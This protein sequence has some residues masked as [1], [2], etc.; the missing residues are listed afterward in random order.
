M[1]QKLHPELGWIIKFKIHKHR[2]FIGNSSV[3]IKTIQFFHAIVK[4]L[5]F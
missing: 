5:I 3:K 2:I 1:L 4:A